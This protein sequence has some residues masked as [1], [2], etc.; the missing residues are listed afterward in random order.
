MHLL[1]LADGL[2]PPVRVGVTIAFA[3][4]ISFALPQDLHA[5]P[6]PPSSPVQAVASVNRSQFSPLEWDALVNEFDMVIGLT[7]AGYDFPG[8]IDEFRAVNQTTPV[9]TYVELT[10]I[11]GG[12]I[13][14]DRYDQYDVVEDVFFHTAEPAS[15][16]VY[17]VSGGL[18]MTW[19][20][21][22]RDRSGGAY[23]APGVEEYLIEKAPSETGPWSEAIA[24]FAED[25]SFFHTVTLPGADTS[26]WYRIRS[27]L[28]DDRIVDY[29]W[30][31]QPDTSPTVIVSG[32][33]VGTTFSAVVYGP[34]APTDPADLRLQVDVN[35]NRVWEPQ[36]HVV[37][38][39]RV[40]L[41]DGYW[42]YS[43]TTGS[44]VPTANYR[45]RLTNVSG[46][47]A[48]ADGESYS[49]SRRNSRLQ[50]RFGAFIFKPDH[51]LAET[52]HTQRLHDALDAGYNGLHLD[53]AYDDM[54]P[55]WI[56]AADVVPREQAEADN[57]PNSVR[58]L[59]GVLQADQPNA[60]IHFNGYF[61]AENPANFYA[62]LD[63]ATGAAFEFF[64][65]GFQ[66]GVTEIHPSTTRSV[67]NI[68]ET[69]HQRN[70]N[71]VAVTLEAADNVVARLKALALYLVI[72]H[73]KIYFAYTSTDHQ[74]VD[75]YP[76]YR[77]PL[78]TPLIPTLDGSNHVHPSSPNV[79]FRKYTHGQVLFNLSET[80]PF[81]LD[82]PET[83]YRLSV[84]GGLD[85]IVGGDGRAFYVPV[86]RVTIAPRDGVIL[87][88]DP[89][90]GTSC[91]TDI[92]GD[93]HVGFSDLLQLLTQWG[94]CPGCPEDVDGGGTV[95]MS[96]L[97]RVLATW[98]PC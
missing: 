3:L 7:A 31:T 78:G 17:N 4:A 52:I 30:P 68:I 42:E 88:T 47:G 82:L 59:I 38:T 93:G 39:D 96:D 45:F 77:V 13:G 64:V 25:G 44:A 10:G 95:G 94:P 62:Y 22:S 20:R 53:F 79:V 8:R 14:D 75:W 56:S 63:E 33:F 43:G 6:A 12:N 72:A 11:Q 84:T 69:S 89:P 28:A 32:I 81:V 50:T 73:E 98:G 23:T 40:S 24:P 2:R 37:A 57:L 90:P 27:R 1:H 54:S 83:H 70:K 51:P 5:A 60:I 71:S 66:H 18:A 21:D 55:T 74:S 67:D 87:V 76:E 86:D 9:L 46:V 65:F 36:E 91:P 48:P 26:A 58:D 15:L 85:P 61:V 29:A 80:T 19:I 49:P 92:L 97:F 35:R 34:D 16:R 41:G